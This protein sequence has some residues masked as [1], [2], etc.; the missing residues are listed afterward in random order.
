MRREL[1]YGS[2]GAGVMN[3]RGFVK[4]CMGVTVAAVTPVERPMRR[5]IDSSVILPPSTTTLR[6]ARVKALAHNAL[7]VARAAGAQYADVRITNTTS[8][9]FRSAIPGQT[10]NIGLSVRALINGYWGWAATPVLSPAEVVRVGRLAAV[11]ATDSSKRSKPRTVD[12]GTIQPVH[13]GDWMTPVKV[14]PFELDVG[15]IQDWCM[16]LAGYVHHLGMARGDLHA[17][18]F[19]GMN[20]GAIGVGFQKQERLFASTDGSLCTQTVILTEPHV[21]FDY[22]GRRPEVAQINFPVQMGW[23]RIVE[24]SIADLIRQA[25]ERVDYDRAHPLPVKP[26]EVGRYDLVFSASAMASLLGATFGPAT[27]L[28]R[29]IGLEANASGTSFLGPNPLKFLGTKVA[30]PLVT[31]TADRSTPTALATIKWDE[32]GV[33]CEDFPLVKD[34]VLVDYQTTREQAVWL[35]PWYEKQGLP[36]QSKGCA[37]A[38]DALAVSMAHTPNLILQ[39]GTVDQDF[40]DLLSRLEYGLVVDDLH[41]NMD[42]QCNT[43]EGFLDGVTEIRHGKKVAR[44]SGSAMLF[45]AMEIWK[46]IQSLGGKK[47]L[48]WVGGFTSTKGEPNQ[49][50]AY[51]IA[52][53][54]ALVK[55]VTIVDPTRKA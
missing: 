10:V 43:G 19:I 14:D 40:D 15:E 6:D 34:G 51:S 22:G 44:I 7:E 23:E 55:Q 31:L 1:S 39:P 26:I 50:T 52:A 54:P 45:K 32:E 36:S 20:A 30:S 38:P 17:G 48:Q 53:V 37:M 13:N 42:F 8:R 41:V 3:R 49:R 29:A 27:D 21:S 9:V 28:A 25:M 46:N 18:A 4:G 33:P 47:S 5:R 2:E 24:T 16:G 12:L 11:L 35:A